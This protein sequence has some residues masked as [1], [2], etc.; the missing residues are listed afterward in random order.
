MPYLSAWPQGKVLYGEM[1]L[2]KIFVK[3]QYSMLWIREPA[4]F[5]SL[6]KAGLVCSGCGHILLLKG[7]MGN[8]KIIR[9]LIWIDID[10]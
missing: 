1:R 9:S 10:F 5:P 8:Y 3:L 7:C 4:Q 2:Q 6:T